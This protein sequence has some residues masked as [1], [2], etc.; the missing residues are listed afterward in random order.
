MEKDPVAGFAEIVARYVGWVEGPVS[1]P[2]EESIVALKLLLDLVRGALDLPQSDPGSAEPQEVPHEEWTRV[3]RR[4]AVLPVQYYPSPDP[5]DL[6]SA[7]L[8]GDLDD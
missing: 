1:A 7:G 2:R 4:F 3:F 8:V 6:A 5:R